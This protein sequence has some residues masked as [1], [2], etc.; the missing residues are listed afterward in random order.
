MYK[1]DIEK[2]RRFALVVSLITLTYS[3]AGISLQPDLGITLVGLTF[4]ILR[5]GLLPVGIV[6]AS[7]YATIRFIY[8]GFML[9]KSPY[10]IRRTILDELYC[11]EP[12]YIK[13]KK[14]PMYFGPTEFE[15]KLSAEDPSSIQ[16][17]VESFPEAFPKFARASPTLQLQQEQAQTIQGSL[18][19][20]YSAKVVIPK[21]CR[22]AAVVQD[23]DYSLPVWLNL[24]SL[25]IFFWCSW[26]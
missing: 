20:V 6:I 14:I 17:Y 26:M 25:S 18:V 3:V 10:R 2:L 1:P 15:T 12:P 22:F 23:I 16:Q 19:T 4:K 8:Y 7:I 21:R 9:Q 24:I 13:G 11:F 5:P